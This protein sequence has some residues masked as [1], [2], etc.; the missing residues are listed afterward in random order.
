MTD[1]I[2]KDTTGYSQGKERIPTTWTL[3]L[4]YFQITVT[5]GHIYHKGLWI[6]RCEP[7]FREL[8]LGVS[9]KE[10]AQAKAIELVQTRLKR[11]L[12]VLSSQRQ[13]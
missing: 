1:M 11:S 7:F 4:D 13:E 3:K 8:E 10:E 5:C 12:D 2:W 6:V 9:T